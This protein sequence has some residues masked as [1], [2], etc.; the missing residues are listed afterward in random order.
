MI[1]QQRY[2]SPILHQIPFYSESVNIEV[3]HPY[4]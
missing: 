4:Q 3:A 2:G 1:V